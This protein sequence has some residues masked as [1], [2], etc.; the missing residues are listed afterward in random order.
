[1]SNKLLK[2]GSLKGPKGDPGFT[3]IGEIA[4]IA[5]LDTLLSPDIT[6]PPK[7][8]DA[9]ILNPAY[10]DSLSNIEEKKGAVWVYRG[11]NYEY[12][13]GA[14]F[15]GQFEYVTNLMGPKGDK[16]EEG[17]NGLTIKGE[18]EPKRLEDMLFPYDAKINDA[19]VISRNA[20]SSENEGGMIISPEFPLGAKRGDVYVCVKEAFNETNDK[21]GTS[22][23]HPP[24][25]E[26]K[27]DISWYGEYNDIHIM[28]TYDN[29]VVEGYDT[30][31]VKVNDIIIDNGNTL[32]SRLGLL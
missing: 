6:N 32:N 13:E 20:K 23:S 27:F 14:F 1:M 18:V 7:I 8:N 21:L 4:A 2:L 15:Y 11:E 17:I 26:K 16:G 24:V 3:I 29:Y 12:Q 28:S 9:W 25:F 19:Y 10:D 22:I 31:E 5:D 30:D